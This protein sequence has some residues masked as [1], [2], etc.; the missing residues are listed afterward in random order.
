[1]Y[2]IFSFGNKHSAVRLSIM[3]LCNLHYYFL[4]FLLFCQ[5]KTRFKLVFLP[6]FSSPSTLVAEA[7]L[8]V[9]SSPS[10]PWLTVLPATRAKTT[11][12]CEHKEPQWEYIEGPWNWRLFYVFCSILDQ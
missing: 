1:M 9:F 11:R 10:T 2:L 5:L 4:Y 8:E 3:F 7:V 12:V 6:M